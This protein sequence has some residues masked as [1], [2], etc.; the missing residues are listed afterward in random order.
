MAAR[1]VVVGVV[2]AMRVLGGNAVGVRGRSVECRDGVMVWGV[3]LDGHILPPLHPP[4][5][6]GGVRVVS[7]KSRMA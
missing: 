7:S 4:C 1:A 3:E 6:S 5:V 2:G